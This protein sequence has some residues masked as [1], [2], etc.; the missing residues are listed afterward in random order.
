MDEIVTN[1]VEKALALCGPAFVLA[2]I[3]FWAVMGH[4]V[5]PPNM[6]GMTGQ[7]LVD[8]YY[9][10]YPE[11]KIGMIVCAA[12]G[13]LYLPWSCLLASML[14]DANG[15]MGVLSMM[16]L[17]GGALTAWVLA[18]CPAI[19]AACAF[20]AGTVDP[21]VTKFV[22]MATWFIYDCTYMITTVQLTGLGLYT[23][24]NK[25]QTIFPAWAGWCALAT[26]A[27]FIPLT[28]LPFV[29][30]G[31]FM[32]PGLWNFYIV[33]T[34]WLF[35]FF[36]VYSYYMWKHLGSSAADRKAASGTVAAQGA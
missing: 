1:R 9:L 26:G 6:M 25:R 23:V 11:I 29:S 19:W 34:T 17:T 18:F 14:R 8:N 12:A 21:E 22:H 10:A 27:V 2:Y 20:T 16:E 13:M 7:E 36:S 3:V 32:L 33:Y 35:A 4:N 30:E 15:N 5:P 31:P 28:V 24:L